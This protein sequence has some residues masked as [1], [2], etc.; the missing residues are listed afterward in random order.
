[1]KLKKTDENKKKH[2]FYSN[3][4]ITLFILFLHFSIFK[5]KK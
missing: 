5:F 3:L 2:L 1:M 4:S